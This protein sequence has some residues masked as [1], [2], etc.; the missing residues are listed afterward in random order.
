MKQSVTLLSVTQW[1]RIHFL[2][3]SLTLLFYFLDYFMKFSRLR[4]FLT[5]SELEVGS[6]MDLDLEGSGH[7]IS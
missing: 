1:F 3:D 6:V 2:V 4:L 5:T 7:E